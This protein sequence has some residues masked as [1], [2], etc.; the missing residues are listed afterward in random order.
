MFITTTCVQAYKQTCTRLHVHV[1]DYMY[2]TTCTRLHVHDYMHTTTCTCISRKKQ[3]NCN[4]HTNHE[5]A[6]PTE[7]FKAYGTY[8]QQ[9]CS[10]FGHT[11]YIDP[12]YN[13][14]HNSH[15]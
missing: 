8:Y 10:S 9:N 5:I 15:T 7:I 11:Q 14:T 13:H 1:H 3:L 2:T 12:T 4:F 6:T